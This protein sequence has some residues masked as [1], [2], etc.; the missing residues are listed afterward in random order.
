MN[1]NF[2]DFLK[3]K[4]NENTFNTSPFS[5]SVD[6]IISN[7]FDKKRRRR[8]MLVTAL[9]TLLITTTVLAFSYNI[10][11]LSSVGI[12][13]TCLN[14][15]TENG[16]IQTLDMENQEFNG[17]SI[18]I[19]KFVIDDINIDILFEY[20]ENNIIQNIK[21]I[22]IQDLTI[23]DE[24]NNLL[25]TSGELENHN[26]ISQTS[27][28]SK[29]IKEREIYKNTFFAQSDNFPKSKKIFV[30]FKKVTLANEKNSKQINGNWNFEIDVAEY[31]VNRENINYKAISNSNNNNII[32]N[33][34]KLT[35]TGL[36]IN[37]EA[38]NS[39]ILNN[40]KITAIVNDEEIIA[41]DNVFE[42]NPSFN[43]K[44]VEYVYTFN[45][46]KY[47]APKEITI[48]IKDNNKESKIIFL[49]N[50]E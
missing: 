7:M 45:L 2:D 1:D 39:E 27:G 18:S 19:S 46:T 8:K 50:E 31:M 16:Y 11:N 26:K 40:A 34:M 5:N 13:D 12:D 44:L 43:K 49:K 14:L 3:R 35:N 29:T 20:K 41:N 6:Q 30:K 4:F 17:L 22:Y 42:K 9:P 48:K 23:V 47:D 32:I 28:Y 15:A 10:F 24:D 37:A 21:N 38:Q 33:N 36:I 25:H